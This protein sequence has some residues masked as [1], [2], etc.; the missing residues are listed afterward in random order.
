MGNEMEEPLQH[1]AIKWILI[2]I[3]FVVSFHAGLT[4]LEYINRAPK[5][6]PRVDHEKK[7]P[8]LP[9]QESPGVLIKDRP[10]RSPAKEVSL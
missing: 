1:P 3:A 8:E 2:I 4:F 6:I 10:W 5:P 9:Q 7:K